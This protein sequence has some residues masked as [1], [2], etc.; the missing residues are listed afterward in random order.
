MNVFVIDCV[1]EFYFF[2]VGCDSFFEVVEVLVL[3]EGIES[4]YNVDCGFIFYFGFYVFGVEF[5]DIFVGFCV[6]DVDEGDVVVIWNL[7]I[8]GDDWD[9]GFFGFGD[10]R[11]DVVYVDGYEDDFVN[12]L[13]DVVFD[14]VVLC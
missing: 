13:C 6:V 5:V 7:C 8:D 9:V 11:F 2:V 14:G 10:G 3:N 4:V 12:F 1:E